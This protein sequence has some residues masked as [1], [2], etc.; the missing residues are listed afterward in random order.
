MV[1][2]PPSM[3]SRW[4][5]QR[6]KVLLPDP[7]GPMTATTSPLRKVRETPSSTRLSPKDLMMPW[8]SIMISRE[9]EGGT[10]PLFVKFGI[11]FFHALE[12][13]GQHQ[14]H[15][16]VEDGRHQ[17]GGGR[18]VALHDATGCPQDVVER[19]HVDERGVLHQR[20][21]LVAHGGQHPAYHLRQHDAPQRL[22]VTEAQHLAAL[23]L[24]AIHRLNAGTEDLGEIGGVIERKGD[25]C[26]R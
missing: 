4:F 14:R 2:E 15:D 17:E 13:P 1:M 7:D 9:S 10:A 5:R 26:R 21:G 25:D 18:E 19:Q 23:V 16:K 11:T 8:A 3:I 20:D 24:A 12:E 6:R 22:Q